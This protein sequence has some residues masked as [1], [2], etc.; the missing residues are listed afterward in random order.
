MTPISTSS[1]RLFLEATLILLE[2]SPARYRAKKNGLTEDVETKAFFFGHLVDC[3]L[4]TPEEFNSRF[5]M[6]PRDMKS[7]SSPQ[8]QD[9]CSLVVGGVDPATSYSRC[10]SVKGK[11]DEDIEKLGAKLND[12]LSDYLSF[13][14]SVEDHK[15]FTAEQ[16]DMLVA[17]EKNVAN[18]PAA[19]RFLNHSAFSSMEVKSQL[20]IVCK[21]VMGLDVKVMID[22]MV[23]DHEN[24]KVYNIDL[25]TTREDL[26]NFWMS[27]K[28]YD[29]HVQQA[30]Y[31]YVLKQ[32]MISLGIGDYTVETL[33]I[34]VE[35]ADLFECRVFSIQD[36]TIIEGMRRF[37]HLMGLMKWHM[38]EGVWTCTKWEHMQG[39]IT[40]LNWPYA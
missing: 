23:I 14:S 28:K 10:Y 8:Q 24:K 13:M 12:E 33:V 20:A 22:R 1:T 2:T 16:S 35:K 26:K 4:L 6:M 39:H 29:Y 34:A 18:N 31:G 25:K 15:I 30:M 21:D 36:K 40:P 11:K 32:Y 3:K 17:I 19:N 9:F 37:K 7:P 38:D 27:Y 5:K